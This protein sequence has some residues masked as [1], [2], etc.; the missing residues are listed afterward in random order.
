[1]A[2]IRQGLVSQPVL[3]RRRCE[4]SGLESRPDVMSVFE[5]RVIITLKEGEDGG[6]CFLVVAGACVSRAEKSRREKE[7]VFRC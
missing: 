3:S 2:M 4:D 5:L 1:M 6:L 7:A